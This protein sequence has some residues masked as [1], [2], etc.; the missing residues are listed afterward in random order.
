LDEAGEIFDVSERLLAAGVEPALALLHHHTLAMWALMQGRDDA[1]L[2]FAETAGRLADALRNPLRRTWQR[3]YMLG[4]LARC[5]EFERVDGMIA[6]LD[7]DERA[8]PMIRIGQAWASLSRGEPHAATGHL[9]P[10]IDGSPFPTYLSWHRGHAYLLAA[11][12][13]DALDEDDAAHTA[14]ET[15][16]AA[17]A[18]D[19][20]QWS[21]L[22]HRP[23]TL[24]ARHL[25]RGTAYASFIA[26]LLGG[27][28]AN[29]SARVNVNESVPLLTETE[30][31]VLRYLPSALSGPEIANELY[32]SLSTVKT[33]MR[34]LYEKL[35]VH[36]RTEAVERARALGLLA[37]R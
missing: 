19:R 24:L 36:R 23:T 22:I 20:M 2:R 25:E 33:H 11:M 28:D 26:E 5:G 18:P 1:A 16:L 9:A 12:A 6:E 32:C 29:A 27:L 4:F 13:H 31:R 37:S 3:G 8:H 30:L 7:D 17:S 35:G 21:F 10:L 14:L 15:A 34:H